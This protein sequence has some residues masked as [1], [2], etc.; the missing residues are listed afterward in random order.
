[1]K[2]LLLYQKWP[3]LHAH[4]EKWLSGRAPADRAARLGGFPCLLPRRRGSE[5]GERGGTSRPPG[6]VLAEEPW[7]PE[8]L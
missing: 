4:Q 2:G 6:F 7:S 5:S 3:L 1:M 8:P